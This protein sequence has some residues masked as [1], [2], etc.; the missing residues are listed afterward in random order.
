MRSTAGGLIVA[1]LMTFSCAAAAQSGFLGD[2]QTPTLHVTSADIAMDVPM[3][4]SGAN[5]SLLL[6]DAGSG[7]SLSEL[8]EAALQKYRR[9]LQGELSLQLNTFFADEEVPLVAR[10]GQLTLQNRLDI[11]VIKHFSNLQ[12]DGDYD[13][14]RGTVQLEGHFYY[15]LRDLSGRTLRERNLDIAS[16]DVREA[17]RVRTS[18]S[19]ETAEDNTE[20]AI[21]R[22]LAAMVEE[23][24]DR[25]DGELDAGELEDLAAG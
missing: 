9:H 25:I 20:E 14:E 18:R 22:A 6:A 13:L 19:G 5:L 23:I 12:R 1:G 4:V 24:L 17:Y 11:K 2:G 7:S 21:K 3:P 10:E 8:K 15:R 16:L